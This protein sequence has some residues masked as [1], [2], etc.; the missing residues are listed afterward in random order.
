MTVSL[1]LAKTP[2]PQPISVVSKQGFPLNEEKMVWNVRKL[3][4]LP[5]CLA[6]CGRTE[7]LK[8]L[9]TDHTW[10]SAC[11]STMPCADIINWFSHVIPVVPLGRY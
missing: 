3:T 1:P 6:K 9:L 2:S 8:E 11:V 4:E 10:L 7:E 5:Y